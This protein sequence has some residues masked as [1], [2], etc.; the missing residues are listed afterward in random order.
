MSNATQLK[1]W[2]DEKGYTIS[3]LA[4]EMRV[5]YDLVYKFTSGMRQPTPGFKWHFLERFGCEEAVRT[6]PIKE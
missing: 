1:T 4:R 5:S 6:F 2:M 3:Q